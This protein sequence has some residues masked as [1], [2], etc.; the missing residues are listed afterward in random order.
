[1][2]YG[3]ERGVKSLRRFVIGFVS[4]FLVAVLA[5]G[6]FIK[7]KYFSHKLPTKSIKLEDIK[8]VQI[9]N[10]DRAKDRREHYEKMLH[11]N[12]GDKFLGHKIGEEIRFRAV[13]GKKD[14]IL[15]NLSTGQK[16]DYNQLK[17]KDMVEIF[18][19]DLWKGY[20]H[21]EKQYYKYFCNSISH[22]QDE[23]LKTMF[24]KFGCH[25]SFLKAISN[26]AKQPDGTWGIIF[27]DDFKVEKDFYQQME[28]I[29]SKIP[30]DAAILK[31][32]IAYKLVIKDGT[33][34]W[35]PLERKKVP[36]SEIIKSGIYR[37]ILKSWRKFG[38]SGDWVRCVKNLGNEYM[39]SNA[40]FMIKAETA[41]QFLKYYPSHIP[42]ITGSEGVIYSPEEHNAYVYLKDMP[43]T[44]NYD[45]AIKSVIG[46]K[47]LNDKK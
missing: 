19:K 13:D 24:T 42:P 11:D 46:T 30:A 12:F 16:F 21:G 27:E 10:L 7:C 1:M 2:R 28:K 4:I 9:I 43:V 17:D 47:R 15:E 38:Y 44:I 45:D 41:R 37:K 29:L 39:S 23:N 5:S 33:K 36:F 26:V 35:V 3:R 40:C 20:I 6:I 14:V 34:H 25:L 18:N 22:D 32:N 31:L 8:S